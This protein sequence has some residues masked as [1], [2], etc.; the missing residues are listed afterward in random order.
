MQSTIHMPSPKKERLCWVAEVTGVIA[1]C[2]IRCQAGYTK[3]AWQWIQGREHA[4]V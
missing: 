3:D 2:V 1:A 4:R